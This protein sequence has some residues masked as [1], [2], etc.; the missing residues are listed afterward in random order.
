MATGFIFQAPVSNVWPAPPPRATTCPPSIAPAL[1]FEAAG[2]ER[3]RP[4]AGTCLGWTGR[5][6]LAGA[7]PADVLVRDPAP[8]LGEPCEDLHYYLVAFIQDTPQVRAVFSF[9]GGTARGSLPL[10]PNQARMIGSADAY[11]TDVQLGTYE[12]LV[13]NAGQ[14]SL[15]CRLDPTYHLYCPSTHAVDQLC[16]TWIHRSRAGLP[17]AQ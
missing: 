8:H 9:A 6:F 2:Q 10:S 1:V 15:S 13:P 11:V 5:N 3:P 7:G 16:L 4:A 12:P 17:L 14:S